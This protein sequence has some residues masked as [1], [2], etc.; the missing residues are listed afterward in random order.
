MFRNYS[1]RLL[2]NPVC[3]MDKINQKIIYSYKNNFV[4]T[5]PTQRS[6]TLI[7]NN[8]ELFMFIYKKKSIEIL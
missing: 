7:I 1:L 2:K 3:K 6:L 4:E 5:A 8:H